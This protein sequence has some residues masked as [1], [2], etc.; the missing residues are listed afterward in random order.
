V[1]LEANMDLEKVKLIIRNIEM[2][3]ETLK[4]E[5]YTDAPTFKFDDIVVSED[6]YDQIMDDLN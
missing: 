5:I 1:E 6:D 3:L 4:S 2:L